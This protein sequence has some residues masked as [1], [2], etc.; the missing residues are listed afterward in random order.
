MSPASTYP[1]ILS[2]IQL[3]FQIRRQDNGCK[4]IIYQS[5]LQVIQDCYA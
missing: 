2:S 3:P 1:N 5:K 4:H